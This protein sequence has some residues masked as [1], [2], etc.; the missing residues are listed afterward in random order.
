VTGDSWKSSRFALGRAIAVVQSSC[1]G[2]RELAF[3]LHCT[4]TTVKNYRNGKH[5]PSRLAC[6]QLARICRTLDG[7]DSTRTAAYWQELAGL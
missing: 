5:R 6:L 1:G 3:L 7:P 4:P 2:E